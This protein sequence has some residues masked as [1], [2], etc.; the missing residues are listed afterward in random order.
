M[1]SIT[2]Y[3]ILVDR[4]FNLRNDKRTFDKIKWRGSNWT[5][6]TTL[7]IAFYNNWKDRN[8]GWCRRMHQV[9][10]KLNYNRCPP[11]PFLFCGTKSKKF[12]PPFIY[13][14]R[15][16]CGWIQYR[17]YHVTDGCQLGLVL[18]KVLLVTRNTAVVWLLFQLISWAQGLPATTSSN[19]GRSCL[20]LLAA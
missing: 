5:I 13:S 4:A 10:G 15:L 3:L 2:C 7:I 6:K 12:K 9:F 14:G 8:D 1:Q 16:T 17:F 11:P 20:P 18:C 19:I